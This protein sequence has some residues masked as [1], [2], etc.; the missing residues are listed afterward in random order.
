MVQL[1]CRVSGWMCPKH[2]YHSCIL[3][4]SLSLIL[5]ILSQT[6]SL[7]ILSPKSIWNPPT[8][9]QL[10]ATLL[11]WSLGWLQSLFYIYWDSF[12]SSFW[13]ENLLPRHL[14]PKP[15]PK[16]NRET[17]K[18]ASPTQLSQDAH[19]LQ[20]KSGVPC[21]L[22]IAGLPRSSPFPLSL[23][24]VQLWLAWFQFLRNSI[25]LYFPPHFLTFC[26]LLFFLWF[27]P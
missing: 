5:Y 27:S 25:H 6:E 24:V 1:P 22:A 13:N 16:Q 26:G 11:V 8:S 2:F 17:N 3:V 9:P 15:N 21:D 19:D 7:L 10:F 20:L 12:P 4:F 23:S 14:P 18:L